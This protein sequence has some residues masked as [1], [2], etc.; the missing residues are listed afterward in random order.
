MSGSSI[1]L[2]GNTSD[3]AGPG[4][5]GDRANHLRAVLERTPE[6]TRGAAALADQARVVIIGGGVGG[7]S[8]AYHLAEMGWTD[9]L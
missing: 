3:R 9:V 8:I 4:E 5:R 7:T 1:E 6:L 2:P